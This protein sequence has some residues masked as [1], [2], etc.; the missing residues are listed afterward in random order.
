[1]TPYWAIKTRP[2][3]MAENRKAHLYPALVFVALC[4]LMF[5]LGWLFVGLAVAG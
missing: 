3:R 1:M 2:S 4:A 5:A